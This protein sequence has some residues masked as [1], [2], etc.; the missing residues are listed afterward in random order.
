MPLEKAEDFGTNADGSPS[1]DYCQ[2]CYVNGA[3]AGEFTMEQ[4][5]EFCAPY[6]VEIGAHKD[7][8]EARAA[9]QGYF[10]K[11]KRWATA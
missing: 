2:Y 8:D 1:G 11:L 6:S 10:P 9:M 5:I 3:F 7:I 4:M